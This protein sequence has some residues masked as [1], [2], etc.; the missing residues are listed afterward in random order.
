VEPTRAFEE[1]DAERATRFIVLT[2]EG[3]GSRASAVH[4]V[5]PSGSARARPLEL[6]RG[7]LYGSGSGG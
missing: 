5:H 4:S 1:A 2:G 6:A 7:S 3:R